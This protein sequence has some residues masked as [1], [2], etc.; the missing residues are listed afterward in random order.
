MTERP[1]SRTRSSKTGALFIKKLVQKAEFQNA[2]DRKSEY[3]NI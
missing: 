2:E 3:E 1:N